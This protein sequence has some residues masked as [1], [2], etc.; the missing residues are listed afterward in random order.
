MPP[1]KPRAGRSRAAPPASSGLR[2]A[3][4]SKLRQ[5]SRSRTGFAR[6]RDAAYELS[7]HQIELEQQNAELVRTRQELEAT[8]DMYR[9]LYDSAPIGY[10]SVDREGTVV[11]ANRTCAEM[12]GVTVE[13][14]VGQSFSA[15][16]APA[17]QDTNHLHHRQVIEGRQ[18]HA[19]DIALRRGGAPDV[20][21]HVQSVPQRGRTGLVVGRRSI[22]VDVSLPREL[23]RQILERQRELSHVLRLRTLGELVPALAH[24]INQP[25]ASIHAFAHGC[26]RRLGRGE[27]GIAWLREAFAR[28]HAQAARAAGIVTHLGRL[29]RKSAPVVETVSIDRVIGEVADLFSADMAARRMRLERSIAPGLP[30]VRVNP[31]E[32]QQVIMNL[33][34]NGVEAMAGCSPARRVLTIA[35]ARRDRKSVAVTVS[36]RGS[37]LG[38]LD[39]ERLFAPFYSTKPGGLGLGLS[40]SR[41]IAEAHGGSLSC[42][43]SAKLGVTFLLV[44]PAAPAA[45]GKGK[46]LYP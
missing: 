38:G 14:L 40:L 29:I 45:R 13:H 5:R 4:E 27:R 43:P 19:C 41:R 11:S 7:V 36:D 25:L 46:P 3:A 15:F 42:E 18:R 20:V 34:L 8:R 44:L 30:P 16:V 17:S 9:D 1:R 24:E 28:I 12:L 32:L 33:M 6:D 37:G 39:P 10:V 31:V 2:E 35:A 21:V 22:L 23:E 26:L